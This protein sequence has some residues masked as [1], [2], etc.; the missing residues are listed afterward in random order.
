MP[1]ETMKETDVDNTIDPSTIP[2]TNTKTT[3]V[4]TIDSNNLSIFFNNIS[5][6][7]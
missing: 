1:I 3:V 6:A 4:I 2:V 7:S 5:L